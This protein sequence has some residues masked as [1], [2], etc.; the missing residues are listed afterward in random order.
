MKDLNNKNL[1][2]ISLET[3]WNSSECAIRPWFLY[4]TA[5]HDLEMGVQ[6]SFEGSDTILYQEKSFD[7]IH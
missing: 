2:A 7:L 4:Q 1:D 5:K 6:S 3:T